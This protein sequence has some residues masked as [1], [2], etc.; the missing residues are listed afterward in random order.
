[1]QNFITLENSNGTLN[2]SL[3]FY[4]LTEEKDSSGYELYSNGGFMG[5]TPSSQQTDMGIFHMFKHLVQADEKSKLQLYS[6]RQ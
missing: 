3:K 2:S 1:M 6:M 4:Y 5:F